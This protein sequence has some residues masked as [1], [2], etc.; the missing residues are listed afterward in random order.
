MSYQEMGRTKSIRDDVCL[1]TLEFY[2]NDDENERF[3][4][5]RRKRWVSTSRSVSLDSKEEG[6]GGRGV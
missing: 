6:Y 1:K 5:Y 2:W 4:K 3:I